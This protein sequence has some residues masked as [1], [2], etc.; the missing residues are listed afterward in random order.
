V[1]LCAA[2]GLVLIS[3]SFSPCFPVL[4]KF[5]MFAG[6]T[7]KSVSPRLDFTH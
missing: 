5:S 2:G 4:F 7:K 3:V 6:R 1:V